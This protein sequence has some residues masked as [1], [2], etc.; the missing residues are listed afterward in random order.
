MLK[1]VLRTNRKNLKTKQEYTST[2]M[3]QFN[4][5]A[6]LPPGLKIFDEYSLKIV[7]EAAAGLSVPEVLAIFNVSEAQLSDSPLDAEMFS[8]AY[9]RGESLAKVQAVKHL[10]KQMSEKNGAPATITYLKTRA[11]LWASVD[12]NGGAGKNFSFT[13]NMAD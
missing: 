11:A 8:A 13:V 7:E 4:P 6:I 2:T 9:A 10:F 1:F 12:E 3:D 5:Y